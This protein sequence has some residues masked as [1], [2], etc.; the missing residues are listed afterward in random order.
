M[1]EH[2]VTAPHE[3]SLWRDEPEQEQSQT[4]ILWVERKIITSDWEREYHKR[5]GTR[6]DF[7]DLERRGEE[8]GI[9]GTGFRSRGM[10]A[11]RTPSRAGWLRHRH[12][13][14]ADRDRKETS[15]SGVEAH[16]AGGVSVPLAGDT[17][18]T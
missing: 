4:R 12:Q 3:L 5:D 6:M 7:S 16:R 15:A 2:S 18:G 13:G 1:N 14:T 17:T 10:A 8:K 9:S 11:S